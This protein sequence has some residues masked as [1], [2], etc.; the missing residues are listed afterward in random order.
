MNAK[1]ILVM[2][3]GQELVIALFENNRIIEV[4]FTTRVSTD[5]SIGDIYIGKVQK[6][7]SSMKACFLIIDKNVECYLSTR[8]TLKVGDEILVQVQQEAIKSKQ[9]TVSRNLNFSGKYAVLTGGN[10][11]LSVSKKLNKSNRERMLIIAKDFEHKD[12]G[13][14]IRTDAVSATEEQIRTE[15][16]SLVSE[17]NNLIQIAPTRTCFSCLKKSE[18]P[19][20]EVI[21][22]LFRNDTDEIVVEDVEVYNCLKSVYTDSKVRYYDDKSYS[23]VKLYNIESQI[24]NALNKKVW[25]KSGAFLV[26]EHTEAMTVIDVNTGKNSSKKE[27]EEFFLKINKEAAEEIAYQIRLRNISGIIIVDLINMKNRE[28]IEKISS[29]LNQCLQKDRIQAKL[30]DVTKLQLAEIT[31]KKIRK[32]LYEN[33][34]EY[35]R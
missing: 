24:S 14:I 33:Y 2:N 8:D 26:I 17:Y 6:V 31:R 11:Q 21:K 10:N 19:Y 20:L 9:L 5:P 27:K 30:I 23:L 29:F 18:A 13:W 35:N 12:Y 25:L 15:M 7:M 16:L 1:K 3:Y 4:V 32:N 28:N 34:K 22:E